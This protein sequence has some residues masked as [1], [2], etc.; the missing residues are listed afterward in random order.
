MLLSET[1]A[2]VSCEAALLRKLKWSRNSVTKY[3]Y[4]RGDVDHLWLLS[5]F[6]LFDM[7]ASA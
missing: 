1:I 6:D 3:M 2:L 7:H 4:D 5:I